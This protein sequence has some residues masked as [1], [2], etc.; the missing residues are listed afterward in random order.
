MDILPGA[1][2]GTKVLMGPTPRLLDTLSFFQQIWAVEV[3]AMLH[4]PQSQN[5]P[6]T[7]Q[8]SVQ[9]YSQ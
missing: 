5:S 9:T 8:V 7:W 3:Y 1:P 2:N 6:W 4:G